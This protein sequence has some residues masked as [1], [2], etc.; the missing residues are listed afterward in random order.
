MIN[1]G[2]FINRCAEPFI[3]VSDGSS[4][5]LAVN[6]SDSYTDGGTYLTL[7]LIHIFKSEIGEGKVPLREN[8]AGAARI[9]SARRLAHFVRGRA[10][11]APVRILWGE[12][13]RGALRFLRVNVVPCARAHL[14]G[15]GRR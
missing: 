12:G 6:I 15:G 4:P 7:S 11:L 3:H 5:A 13:G 2:T 8:K 9:C 1:G 14:C 10:Y